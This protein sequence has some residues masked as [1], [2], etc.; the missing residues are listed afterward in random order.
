MENSL[1]H[2]VRQASVSSHGSESARPPRPTPPAISVE[3]IGKHF[4]GLEVLQD[5]RFEVGVG[6]MVA[7]VGTS[8]CGKSTLLNIVA[9]LAHPDNGTLRFGGR[10][11][12]EGVEPLIA[13]MFQEDRLL[14]WRTALDNVAFGLERLPLLHS[15]RRNRARDALKLVG[16]GDFENAFPHELS[17]GMRSRVAL[18]RSL[19]VEPS[20]LLMDEPFSKLDPQTR[21]H[22]HA[23]ILRIQALKSMTIVFVTHDVE[24]AVVLA[25]RIVILAPRPGRINEISPVTLPRPRIPTDAR[26]AENIRLLRVKI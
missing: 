7:L 22:M 3:G 13:Y 12:D 20:V 2:D 25:D 9:G 23:E 18:A 17:G 24:E 10:T 26:V 19:V 4:G 6:E 1:I 8:G 15:E 14:P 16:L 21:S 11:R 5:I